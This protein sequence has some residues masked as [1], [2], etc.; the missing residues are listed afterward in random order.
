M[1][2]DE[3]KSLVTQMHHELLA[4]IDAQ[5]EPNKDEVINYLK[6]AIVSIEKIDT[7]SISSMEHAKL[8]FSNAYKDIAQKSLSS[9]KDTNSKFAELSKLHKT[10]VNECKDKDGLIDI[11]SITNKFDEIQSH[12]MNEVQR[13]NEVIMQLTQQ[14]KE[15]EESSKLDALTKVFNRKALDS[16]LEEVTSK[17]KLQHELH[18]LILDIDDFKQIN[19][20]Y[21]HV[22]GD[23]VLIFLA[24]ILR[25][26]LRDGDKIFR[27]GGE[28]FIIILNRIDADTC[29]EI[30]KRIVKI[31]GANKLL[32][33]GQT[34]N[35]TVSIGATTYHEGDTP[36]ALISRADKALYKSKHNGKNQMNV[37]YIN[38]N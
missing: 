8:A 30:A 13:A 4:N 27:Y 9:Y 29:Q 16:Y 1:R 17:G 3:L 35:I 6:D 28:E 22:V 37:E 24:N 5:K 38:G 20:E 33:K 34:I 18:L 25:K 2:K 14:V 10:A 23:K 15:L 7:G 32:Y 19:D 36:N 12:M 31:I 26:T 11:S 21:G